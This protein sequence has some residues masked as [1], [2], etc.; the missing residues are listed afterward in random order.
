MSGIAT[1]SRRGFI[2][3]AAIVTGYTIVGLRFAGSAIASVGGYVGLRQQSV[4]EADAKV[5]KIRKSQDNPMVQKLYNHEKGF[6][7]DGP[8]GHMSHRLLHTHYVERG[9][10]VEALKA[11]GV[12]LK[13]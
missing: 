5:Y 3:A 13:L 7:H 4:Y 12:A 10:A 6:L 2:K 8:C 9:A 1:M 11:K